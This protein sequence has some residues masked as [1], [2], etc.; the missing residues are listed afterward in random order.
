MVDDKSSLTNILIYNETQW[1]G[2]MDDKNK[3]TRTDLYKALS[4]AG[5][6]DWAV[7]LQKF[8]PFG[9]SDLGISNLASMPMPDHGDTPSVNHSLPCLSLYPGEFKSNPSKYTDFLNL[10]V[11]AIDKMVRSCAGRSR[12]PVDIEAETNSG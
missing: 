3:Y 4:F 8:L 10:G 6:S 7:D 12:L 11:S 5:T 1:V 2:Y 9:N